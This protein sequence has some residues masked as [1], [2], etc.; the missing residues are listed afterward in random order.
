MSALCH[1]RLRT[2]LT[3]TYPGTHQLP[4]ALQVRE[5]KLAVCTNKPARSVHHIRARDSR[6]EQRGC[7]YLGGGWSARFLS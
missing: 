6:G 4:R 2:T 1:I 3:R 7:R 5:K